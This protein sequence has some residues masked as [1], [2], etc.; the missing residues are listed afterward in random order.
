MA[1]RLHLRSIVPLLL[2]VSAVAPRASAQEP[3]QETVVVTATAAPIRFAEIGRRVLVVTREQIEALPVQSVPELLSY[4][5]SVDVR[6]RGMGG[7]QADVSIRGASFGQSLVLVDGVRMNDAQ[8]A[9][10]NLDLPVLLQDVERLEL[11]SGPGASLHGAD[12]FGGALNIVTRREPP[13]RDAAVSVGSDGYVD[14]R[15]RV[16]LQAGGHTQSIWAGA[17]RSDGFMPD[18]DFRTASVGGRARLGARSSLS[19]GYIDKEFGAN[20]FYGPAPSREWT[21]STLVRADRTFDAPGGW[22]A[23]LRG[24][25]RTHRDRFDYDSRTPGLYENRHRTHAALATVGAD[26]D[27]GRAGSLH[28]GTEAGGDWILSSNLGDHQVGHGSAVTEWRVQP[29]TRATLVSGLRYDGYSRFGSSWSPSFTASAWGTTTVKLRASVGHT[30]RVP[31]FTELYYRDPANEARD[32]LRPERGW[33]YEGGA[34]WVPSSRWMTSATLFHRRDRDIIDW[35]RDSTAE[36]WHT[37][38]VRRLD[39]TGLEIGARRVIGR[40]GSVDAQY[41]WLRSDADAVAQLSKYVLDYARQRAV[42]STALPLGGKA[43]VGGRV[44]YTLR[45]DGRAYTIADVRVARTWGRVRI[46]LEGYNLLDEAYQEV[47]GVDMPGRSVRAGL[48]IVR[49]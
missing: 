40:T 21:G 28:V 45:A 16:D 41:A 11:L 26:R 12:A 18:R 34:D 43:T 38:N 35:V 2:L 33:S 8:S 24:S 36:R 17:S 4:L 25:Y 6:T 5:A 39:T 42:V 37:A 44:G 29:S 14:A 19:A 32:D 47:R 10:H 13:V 30:F 23:Q 27:L 48:E 1:L 3:L 46:F 15:V 49:F 7:T 9:H 22:T 20:G 31:T